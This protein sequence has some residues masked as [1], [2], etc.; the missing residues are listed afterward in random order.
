MAG[1]EIRAMI[2]VAASA[3]AGR[4]LSEAHWIRRR[5]RGGLAGSSIPSNLRNAVS[6]ASRRAAGRGGG[7]LGSETRSSL[8]PA[9]DPGPFETPHRPIHSDYRILFEW[10]VAG[11][12]RRR[13]RAPA[14]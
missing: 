14:A 8:P 3:P 7:G 9:I 11:G 12:R 1:I 10:P 5:W 4:R 13:G 6:I 2:A